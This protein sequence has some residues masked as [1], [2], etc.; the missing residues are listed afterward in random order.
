[1]KIDSK[2]E[3]KEM[4]IQ[5][6]NTRARKSNFE[7]LRIVAMLM[8]IAHHFA[9]HGIQH[10]LDGNV[11]YVIWRSGSFINKISDCLYAPGGKI[12]V[13]VNGIFFD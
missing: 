1:M 2:K 11:T 4:K 5:A 8:I 13:Y 9:S 6:V 10:D 7:L 12:G 3:T